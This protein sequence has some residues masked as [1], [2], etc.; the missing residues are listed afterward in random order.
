MLAVLKARCL[1]KHFLS[2]NQDSEKDSCSGT[3]E[4]DEDEDEDDYRY[5][6]DG[7]D[8]MI[9]DFVVR[10]EEGDDENSNQQGEN[11]TTSQLKLV[12]QNSLCK[13]NMKQGFCLVQIII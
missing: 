7:D 11:L 12:K 3:G 13:L 8:Y 1:L 2:F 5:D 6:E 4:E 10:N 9:D